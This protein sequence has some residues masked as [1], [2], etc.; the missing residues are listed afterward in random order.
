MN[1]EF[2]NEMTRRA[3][4]AN[5]SRGIGGLALTSLLGE[6]A[7]HAAAAPAKTAPTVGGVLKSLPYPVK[8]KRVIWMTMAGGPSHMETFDPK[9][10]LLEMDGKPMPESFTNGQQIAQ[11]Q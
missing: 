5:G 8:A 11:L 3:F 1:S 9:P 7:A 10:K 4:L 2:R 6:G